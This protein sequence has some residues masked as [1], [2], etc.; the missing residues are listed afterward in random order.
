MGDALDPV[1]HLRKTSP[2]VLPEG[3]GFPLSDF[4]VLAKLKVFKT[5]GGIQI[6]VTVNGSGASGHRGGLLFLHRI[7]NREVG[8]GIFGRGGGFSRQD[9]SGGKL[10]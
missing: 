10:P 1:E 6:R 7:G 9:D 2:P 5:P 8:K 3:F 4:I